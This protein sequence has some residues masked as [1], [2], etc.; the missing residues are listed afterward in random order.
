MIPPPP[1]ADLISAF[2]IVH[3]SQASTIQPR[4]EYV[5]AIDNVAARVAIK[6]LPESK[7]LV[8][9]RGNVEK[10][11]NVFMNHLTDLKNV[12]ES[13][14][15]ETSKRTFCGYWLGRLSNQLDKIFYAN[16]PHYIAEGFI[17]ERGATVIDVGAFDGGTSTV[18][19]EMG[20]TVYGFEM[21]KI[22]FE[23]AK[24]VAEEKN[25]VIENMGLGSYNHEMRYNPTGIY[26]NRWN[27]EGKEIAKVITL[28]SY[29]R[30]NNIPHVDFIKLDVEGAE[31]DVLQGSKTTIA[32]YKPILALSAYHKSD[33]F[34]TL[35]NFLKSIRH[36]YEFAMRQY[37]ETREDVPLIFKKGQEDF[38]VSLGIEPDSRNFNECVLFAR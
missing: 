8:I 22:S 15:D 4:P 26:S 5:L 34:W 38:F 3:L 12:Y 13:L 1:F 32:R 11:Y 31:L 35:M 2:K 37:P 36:D 33:D 27:A 30:E 18:F 17:P 29:I 25:F 14:I 10:D 24:L 23:K 28:D 7:V 9:N 20:Y 21:D 6:N 16:T 19:S